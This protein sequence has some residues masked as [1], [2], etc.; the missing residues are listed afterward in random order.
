MSKLTTSD[1]NCHSC[2]SSSPFQSCSSSSLRYPN[3]S[4]ILSNF[5]HLL[6]ISGS[7]TFQFLTLSA[8]FIMPRPSV[9]GTRDLGA[10]SPTFNKFNSISS[11]RV[12]AS[13]RHLKR[14]LGEQRLA[15]PLHLSTP[16]SPHQF[17]S[18][19]VIKKNEYHTTLPSYNHK[20]NQTPPP[21]RCL[22]K[23]GF[24]HRSQALQALL[25]KHSSQP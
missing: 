24:C 12:T 11:S 18:K 14:P 6:R 15:H 7:P 13:P 4:R 20:C 25:H 22:A 17:F 8:Q 23:L 10:V 3:S 16:A 5:S 21:T 9:C 1:A 2:C 19:S